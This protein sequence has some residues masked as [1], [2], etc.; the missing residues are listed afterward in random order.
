MQALVIGY[1]SIGK[2]HSDVL[3]SLGCEVSVVSNRDLK[4]ERCYPNITEALSAKKPNYIVIANKTSDHIST[5]I[6]IKKI[7]FKGVILIEKPLSD[8]LINIPKENYSD[9]FV[10]YNMRFNPLIQRLFDELKGQTIISSQAYVGQ[11]LPN[12]RPNRDYRES[13]SAKKNE[14]GGVLRDL[15]HEL[16]FLNWILGGWKRVAALGGK[17]SELDIDSD[18]VFGL[19]FETVKCPICIL[20]LNYLDRATR[21]EVIVNT[22]QNVFRIDFISKTF[23][24]DGVI[25]P[26]Y[27]DSNYSYYMQH[28]AIIEKNYDH[29]CSFNSGKDIMRLII[30]AEKSAYKEN[31]NWITNEKNL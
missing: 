2:R 22:S 30:A 25:I 20:Q 18:D 16:D 28:K 12:W 14:G 8:N 15:S 3:E 29:I 5:L 7:G 27:F 1:G 24:K 31:N 13:Y 17:Y 4:M 11:Y 23:E 26:S 10:A 19:M 6:K 9:V 21:R